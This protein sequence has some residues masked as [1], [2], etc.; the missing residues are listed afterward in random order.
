V[1]DSIQNIFQS[2]QSAQYTDEDEDE[3]SLYREEAR[4]TKP[5]MAY[6]ESKPTQRH[7][8][9]GLNRKGEGITEHQDRALQR[10][11]GAPPT[12]DHSRR[13]EKI[14]MYGGTAQNKI[15]A[16]LGELN[17]GLSKEEDNK[18]Y[19]INSF[20]NPK[21]R[22]TFNEMQM[23]QNNHQK[24]NAELGQLEE[25]HFGDPEGESNPIYDTNLDHNYPSVQAYRNAEVTPVT[26]KDAA[27][28][29]A[30]ILSEDEDEQDREPG[31]TPTQTF[32]L[33]KGSPDELKDRSG[34]KLASYDV[35]TKE[36]V[37]QL[38]PDKKN[39][40]HN[41]ELVVGGPSS[42]I[43]KKPPMNSS[44]ATKKPQKKSTSQN[45][46]FVNEVGSPVV[47]IDL[48][49]QNKRNSLS[50]NKASKKE[51]SLAGSQKE[52]RKPDLVM[53][54]KD[55]GSFPQVPPALVHMYGQLK[56]Y[57]DQV[58]PHN[59]EKSS[60]NVREKPFFKP[61]A[62]SVQRE[63]AEFGLGYPIVDIG[64]QSYKKSTSK[65]VLDRHDA[66][67]E[68]RRSEMRE[69]KGYYD[70][71]MDKLK[72]KRQESAT[73][74]ARSIK[75]TKSAASKVDVQKQKLLETKM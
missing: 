75:S 40:N 58:P 57:E 25:L 10:G 21:I 74:S 4:K 33:Q 43:V 46:N 50:S 26:K 69:A 64:G 54:Q 31:L 48:S 38:L 18:S 42:Q 14:N 39:L 72:R 36:R 17:G 9:H 19:S 15:E 44:G 5:V 65:S 24:N 32:G 7:D 22:Q 11:Y 6:I 51:N 1:A 66:H 55:F 35:W 56:T 8:M 2:K 16:V 73:K 67:D 52:Q 30:D 20:T 27:R 34:L 12:F 68:D 23:L 53:K 60:P 49:E 28:K 3:E 45:R 13:T 63:T 71:Q 41:M 47:G 61:P 59:H 37:K 62:E 29:N 70:I